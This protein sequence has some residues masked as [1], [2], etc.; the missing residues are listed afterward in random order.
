MKF[1]TDYFKVEE[2]KKVG[3][4]GYIQQSAYN[5]LTSINR[6]PNWKVA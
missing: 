3:I 1:A 4:F 5:I 6:K 2:A